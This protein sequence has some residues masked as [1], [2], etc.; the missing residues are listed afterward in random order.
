MYNRE[1]NQHLDKLR[2]EDNLRSLT[3]VNIRGKYIDIDSKSYL[4]FSSND[5]LGLTDLDLQ[6]KFL[7]SLD[8]EQFILSNPSSRL[9]TGNS[10]HYQQLEHTIEQLYTNK[11]AL[12]L[13][14]GFMV[15]S[16]VL[17]AL[18]S[19]NDLIIADKLVHASLI[20]G[21]KLSEAQ[22]T[23][24]H[25]NDMNHLES[26]LKKTDNQHNTRWV[27]TESIFSMDGDKAPLEDLIFLKQKYGFRIY[28]DEAH[29][30]GV[31][32]K[33]ESKSNETARNGAGWASE[34]GLE[35]Q[36]DV[37]VATLGKAI[38]SSGAFVVCSEAER[39]MLINRMRTLI[40]STASAPI[41]LMWSQFLIERMHEFEPRRAH[42]NKLINTLSNN[43]LST[44]I[45]PFIV[46]ENSKAIALSQQLKEE[47]YWVSPVR[48]P[49]V[50]K[51]SA[52]IRVSLSAALDQ[53]DVTKFSEL[54]KSIL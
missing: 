30:F 52:R 46:G 26:I 44:H 22:W 25:H 32:G 38:S 39:E 24:F 45:L 42:L 15:N 6:K 43:P 40:F 16:G 27:V 10:T 17:P 2:Q 54:C 9:I 4:N 7:G 23:R 34:L 1:L 20:D 29:S 36:I 35:D 3:N 50:A 18:T 12:C 47:G 41:N 5:Y 8:T 11:K 49:T 21:L 19:K 37:I 13:S 51:G 53:D 31:Y 14:S 28:L 48:Y 33:T